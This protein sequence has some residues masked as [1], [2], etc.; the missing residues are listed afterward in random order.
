MDISFTICA[1]VCTVTDFSAED[2]ASGAKFCT[3]V[4]LHP[5]QGISHFF[6]KLC[7]PTS[8][9]SDESASTSPPQ[10]APEHMIVR[11]VDMGLTCVDIC[12]SPNE[13]LVGHAIN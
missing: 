7:S 2:K 1:C 4:H 8:L 12:V 5:R 13:V 6:Y 3:T 11:R 9:K 10:R